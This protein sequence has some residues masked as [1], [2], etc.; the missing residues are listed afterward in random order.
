MKKAINEYEKTPAP[1]VEQQL[2]ES[3]ELDILS[4]IIENYI[5]KISDTIDNIKDDIKLSKQGVR[6]FAGVLDPKGQTPQEKIDFL[7]TRSA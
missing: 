4:Y 1:F 2:G 3:F 7:E 6:E 5:E